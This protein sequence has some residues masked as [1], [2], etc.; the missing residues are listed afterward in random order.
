MKT[1]ALF[2][3]LGFT[4]SVLAHCAG[5]ESTGTGIQSSPL[6]QQQSQLE[7]TESVQEMHKNARSQSG[8]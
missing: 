1:L 3:L 8:L 2:L 5:N 7:R 4:A 6:Y